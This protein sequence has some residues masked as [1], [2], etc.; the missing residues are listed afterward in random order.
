[1]SIIT[2]QDF[3]QLVEEKGPENL[4][5]LDLRTKEAFMEKHIPGAMNIA[6]D[7][8]QR[9]IDEL[10]KDEEYYLICYAGNFSMLG[11]RYLRQQGFEAHNVQLG[12]AGYKG[13]TVSGE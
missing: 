8:L 7:E 9:K 3:Q 6:L 1:M 5:I 13:V 12:M 10:N 4:N 11:G 2:F